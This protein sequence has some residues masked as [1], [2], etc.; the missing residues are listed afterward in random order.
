[1]EDYAAFCRQRAVARFHRRRRW[2]FLSPAWRH[3]VDD[4]RRFI[5]SCREDWQ[6]RS[7][8]ER[9]DAKITRTIYALG[10]NVRLQRTLARS[11]RDKAGNEP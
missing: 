1:M 2:P 3:E 6:S 8:Q 7:A 10:P 4:A 5:R 9:L 11:Q